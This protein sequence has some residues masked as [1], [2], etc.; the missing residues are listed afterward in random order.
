MTQQPLDPLW[1]GI[2]YGTTFIGTELSSLGSTIWSAL[3]HSGACR[4]WDT[5]NRIIRVVQLRLVASG[6]QFLKVERKV[7]RAPGM[8]S[9]LSASPY[10][11]LAGCHPLGTRS[12]NCGSTTA[13]T[14]SSESPGLS[15]ASPPSVNRQA[16]TQPCAVDHHS[17]RAVGRYSAHVVGSQMIMYSG[18]LLD[19]MWWTTTHLQTTDHH[20]AMWVSPQSRD[21]VW[22][23]FPL[24]LWHGPH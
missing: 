21:L 16:T 23:P 17:V 19:C 15:S 12:V 24:S 14:S 10:P 3:P 22:S 4:P 20:K 5:H 1:Q 2:C 13:P 9:P 11:P 7:G 8:S 6:L 18:L